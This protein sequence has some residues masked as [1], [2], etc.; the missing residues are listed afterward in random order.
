M[1][2]LP[3]R[4]IALLA[5]GC[6]LALGVG[7]FMTVRTQS[8]FILVGAVVTT[9]ANAAMVVLRRWPQRA[10]GMRFG[11]NGHEL[12]TGATAGADR[13]RLPIGARRHR[14]APLEA[15]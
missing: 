4:P 2:M 9:I 11:P 3:G 12:V 8:P 7:A 1:D 13:D 10:F 15:I 14:S 6:V 5:A